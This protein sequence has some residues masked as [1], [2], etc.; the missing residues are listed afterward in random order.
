MPSHPV[1]GELALM[2]EPMERDAGERV[3]GRTAS[4]TARGVALLRAAHQLLDASPRILDD[5]VILRLIGDSGVREI[6]AATTRYQD[7]GA[8]ALRAHVVLRSRFAEDRLSAAVTRGV[9]Q[10]VVLGAGL[11]TFA[12]RQPDW[13]RPLHIIEVDQS[14][15]QAEKRDLL[16][17]AGVAIPD[18]VTL[19]PV[20]F[21]RESLHDALERQGMDGDER[22]FFSWLGVT[23]YLRESAV[24]DVLRTVATCAPGTEI[25][26]TFAQP[27]DRR[28]TADG[29]PTLAELAARAGEPWVS[30]F[31]P[32]ALERK[33]RSFGFSRVEFLTPSDAAARYFS[34]RADALPPPRRTTIVS[35]TH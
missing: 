25:V 6:E 19:A 4:R 16:A 13:A 24:D 33:L 29:R 21:E 9:S 1:T 12:Y 22:V 18:N 32:Q 34:S 30:Y 3:G 8:R 23:M 28:E 31:E 14:A 11:D 17:A 35:A 27:P 26:F 7:P 10:Y 2:T 15:T 20:D 5:P